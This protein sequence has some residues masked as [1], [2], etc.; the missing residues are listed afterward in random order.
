MTS[1]LSRVA[2]S[3]ALVLTGVVA[4]ATV[5][6][7]AF[8]APA[9]DTAQGLVCTE[10]GYFADPSDPAKFSRCYTLGGGLQRADF[11]CPEGTVF[12]V[13]LPGVQCNFPW[14]L[15]PDNPAYEAPL[16]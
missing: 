16:D 7:S 12:D 14:A 5:G 1:F 15:N 8:A 6:Q 2:V 13:D 11:T 3:A 4:P 10:E 9:A